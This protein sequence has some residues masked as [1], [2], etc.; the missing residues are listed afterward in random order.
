MLCRSPINVLSTA[1]LALSVTAHPPRAFAQSAEFLGP[2]K[3]VKCHK[4]EA[5]WWNEKDGPPP[6]GHV[7]ALA[8]LD[9]PKSIAFANAI[10]LA[11]ADDLQGACIGC[12]ATVFK[13]Q[14]NAGVS[15]EKCHGAGSGYVEIHAEENS[16]AKGVAAGEAD[17]V[18]KPANWTRTCLGCHIT[19]DRRLI[20]AG[21]PSGREF[22]LSVKF[23]IVGAHWKNHYTAPAVA[24]LAR[25]A[26]PSA[27]T[28]TTGSAP[29]PSKTGAPP[30]LP[31]APA[32]S[33]VA[34]TG[35]ASPASSENGVPTSP[36]AAVAAV[37]GRAIAMLES[38]LRRGARLPASAPP[39][40]PKADYRGPDAEL[41]RLQQEVLA[42]ALEALRAPAPA[43]KS[44]D[45]KR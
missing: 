28:R 33:V 34:R 21:H 7:R 14:A 45:P 18:G 24:A 29:T 36:V 30:A 38:L 22:N 40:T 41:L 44:G 42:L 19:T 8:Q 1:V 5:A 26:G 6:R 15:C 37:Q 13:G 39:G 31:M 3:C 43:P 20:D 10:G 2:A 32:V 11:K 16:Y 23:S 27:G 25:Q 17:L 9:G 12:H 4:D 35:P